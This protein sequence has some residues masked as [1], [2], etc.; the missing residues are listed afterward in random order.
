MTSDFMYCVWLHVE[1]ICI[2]G[3]AYEGN[4]VYKNR[5]QC[6]LWHNFSQEKLM[7][8]TFMSTDAVKSSVLSLCYYTLPIPRLM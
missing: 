5:M 2:I 3:R 6:L 4:L 8:L 7:T 1:W